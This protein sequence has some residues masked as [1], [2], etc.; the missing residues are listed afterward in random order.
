[1][2]EELFQVRS[3]P[4]RVLETTYFF[5]EFI[6]SAKGS[7]ARSGQ[8]PAIVWYVRRP[9]S[10]ASALASPSSKVPPS[11]SSSKYGCDQPPCAKPPSVSSCGPPG[12]CTTPS[13][14]MN[15]VMTMRMGLTP[16]SRPGEGPR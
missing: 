5:R 2:R 7:P 13:K 4:P 11:T 10:S 6:R 12:A 9:K 1:M 15:S 14:L 3:A 8:A 16:L